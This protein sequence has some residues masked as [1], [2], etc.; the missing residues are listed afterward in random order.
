MWYRGGIQLAEENKPE[1]SEVK[2]DAVKP[3]SKKDSPKKAEYKDDF[4]YIVRIANTD[5]NGEK[6]AVTAIA[7]IR[8]VGIRMAEVVIRRTGYPSHK[9]LGLAT[10]AE[11]AKIEELLAGIQDQVPE[12]FLNRQKDWI[13]GDEL[14]V[15][16]TELEMGLRDDINRMKMIRCYKGVRHE[17]GQKV[18]GQRTRS[19]GRTGLTLGVLRQKEIAAAGASSKSD[20]E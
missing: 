5:L 10:D 19:N 11:I 20:K 13:T 12:W 8:G 14:H 18:R 1:K 16:G 9:K 6:P 15:I 7:S 17:T 2:K 4:K 3:D